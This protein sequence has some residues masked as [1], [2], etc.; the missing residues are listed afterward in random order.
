MFKKT[1]VAVAVLFLFGFSGLT[2]A[3]DTT[4]V[5]QNTNDAYIEQVSDNNVTLIKQINN[6]DSDFNVDVSSSGSIDPGTL[7]QIGDKSY[8]L[9]EITMDSKDPLYTY[10]NS[11]TINN[12]GFNNGGLNTGLYSQTVGTHTATISILGGVS[13][14]TIAQSP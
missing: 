13:I 11:Y 1:L 9:A 14:V 12:T 5:V 7:I 4:N 2:L 3:Q 10:E 8:S 6:N